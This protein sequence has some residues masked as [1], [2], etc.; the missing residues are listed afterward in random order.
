MAGTGT[1]HDQSE[2]Q[3]CALLIRKRVLT[4]GQLKA[5][6]DYQR[7][8]GGELKEILVRLNL[9]R[10]QQLAALQ[11]GEPVD[12]AG[13]ESDGSIIDPSMLKVADLTVHRKLLEKIPHELVQRYL[14]ITFFPAGKVSHGIAKHEPL[15]VLVDYDRPLS[16]Q[17]L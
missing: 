16:P 9:V 4:E 13:D 3:L 17:C 12:G 5:A 6:L 10:P 2:S 1:R 7:S 14:L 11:S 8:L 15:T